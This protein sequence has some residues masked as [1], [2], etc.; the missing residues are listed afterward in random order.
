VV[1]AVDFAVQQRIDAARAR[2]ARQQQDRAVRAR[3][4]AYGLVRRH[5]AK[6][7]HLDA[8]DIRAAD[9]QTD[10]TPDPQETDQP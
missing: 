10:A 9:A 2:I 8:L 5:A 4:R 3:R 6:L 1:S 7:A